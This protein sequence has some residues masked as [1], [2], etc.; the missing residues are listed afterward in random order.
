MF[1]TCCKNGSKVLQ[2]TPISVPVADEV[3]LEE[4]DFGRLLKGEVKEGGSNAPFFRQLILH[5][6]LP[7]AVLVH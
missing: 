2:P 7:G 6:G 3:K 1:L 4:L 5:Q